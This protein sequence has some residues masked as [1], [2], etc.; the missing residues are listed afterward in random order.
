VLGNGSSTDIRPYRSEPKSTYAACLRNG[1]SHCAGHLVTH[2]A[3]HIVARYSF[4]PQGG[5]WEDIP[6]KMMGNYFDRTRCHT[7]IY[8]R[9]VENQPSV[10]LGNF[11][12][13][14]LIHP[15]SWAVGAGSCQTA[16]VSG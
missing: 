8:R 11:R 14:M 16:I 4:I 15:K 9:L 13:N 1:G 10:V 6:A 5:N 2:N 3:D 7:G 12:K